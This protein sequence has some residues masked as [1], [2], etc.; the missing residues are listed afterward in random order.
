ML[1]NRAVYY[2]CLYFPYML[3]NT[4]SHLVLSE[5]GTTSICKCDGILEQENKRIV[6]LEQILFQ[7][8]LLRPKRFK[9]LD[10]LRKGLR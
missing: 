8:R 2:M 10:L 5:W 1:K 6:T 7:G 4:V 3:I 9:I